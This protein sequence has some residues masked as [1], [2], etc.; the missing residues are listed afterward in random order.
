[1]NVIS[2]WVCYTA[3]VIDDVFLW[4]CLSHCLIVLL[5]IS[6]VRYELR[7]S[8]YSKEYNEMSERV[9]ECHY[10]IIRHYLIDWL[11]DWLVDDVC[12]RRHDWRAL[13]EQRTVSR[14]WVEDTWQHTSRQWPTSF[15][16]SSAVLNE[17]R[18]LQC[19]ITSPGLTAWSYNEMYRAACVHCESAAVK[20]NGIEL[21]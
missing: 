6:R 14:C 5:S 15:S 21:E 12:Y 11:I 19:F 8:T 3:T 1:M 13:A 20:F 18:S 17:P 4:T 9:N 16:I 2:L 10:C 7:L